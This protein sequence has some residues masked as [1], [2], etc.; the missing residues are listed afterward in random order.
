[1]LVGG[2]GGFLGLFSP[3][4]VT[5]L[6]KADLL[7]PSKIEPPPPTTSRVC[8]C[9]PVNKQSFF[10]WGIR[11]PQKN[12]TS[13]CCSIPPSIKF[14]PSPYCHHHPHRNPPP[15]RHL[16]SFIY[17][18][19]ISNPSNFFLSTSFYPL[20]PPSIIQNPPKLPPLCEMCTP[21]F[22]TFFV[23]FSPFDSPPPPPF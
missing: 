19:P 7:N 14:I 18:I 5:Q 23:R 10:P 13:Q 6:G 17:R 11:P 2:W 16:N 21:S 3:L 22:P 9:L 20:H 15:P 1:M 8:L 4:A 12:S